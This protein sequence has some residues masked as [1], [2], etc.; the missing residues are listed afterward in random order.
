MSNASPKRCDWSRGHPLLVDYHDTEWGVP[1][2]DDRM[3]YEK[4]VLDGA[5]AGLSWLTILKKR[6]AYRAAFHDFD[7]GRVARFD[8]GDVARLM[9]DAGIVRNRQKVASAIGNA[10][11]F[12]S[13]QAEH[14]S[15]DAYIW[16]FVAG[17]PVQNRFRSP[18]DR[19]AKSA[20]SDA[21]SK[22]LK[23]R[24]FSFVGSTIVYAFLQATGIVNDHLTSCFRYR[25][26]GGATRTAP[27]AGARTSRTA[28]R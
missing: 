1:V 17:K 27:K 22:D 14:G 5:Q 12:L 18:T 15:F 4:L 25:A 20:L 2:H 26:V 23:R 13:V 28:G 19:P 24:G 3:W 8:E 16:A 9:Q 11:A 10:R 21:V 7:V 6:A